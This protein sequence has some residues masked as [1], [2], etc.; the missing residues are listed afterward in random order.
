MFDL[1]RQKIQMDFQ[2]RISQKKKKILI[3]ASSSVNK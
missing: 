3:T 2:N 1:V